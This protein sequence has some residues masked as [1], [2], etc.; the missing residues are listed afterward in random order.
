MYGKHFA[1]M[2]NG[3]M[4][5]KPALVFAVWG[6]CISLQRPATRGG[7][8][9]VE[10]NPLLLAAIFA[11]TPE[12][13]CEALTVLEAPDPAS[14]SKVEQGR[15]L[16]LESDRALGP[17][18]Y[19]VVNG[20]K[21]RK[22][23][24]EEERR[25]YLREAQQKHR[26]KKAG[27]KAVDRK[28]LST[29]VNPSQPP[30]TQ[31]EVEVKEEVEAKEGKSTPLP[32]SSAV[33]VREDV[34][35]VDPDSAFEEAWSLVPR[36]SGKGDARKWYLK[37]IRSTVARER[38]IAGI[39]GCIRQMTHERRAIEK[40]PYGSTL[41]TQHEDYID[42]QPGGGN[43]NGSAG[44]HGRRTAAEDAE[45]EASFYESEFHPES[46]T[47]EEYDARKRARREELSPR[48]RDGEPDAE[49]RDRQHAAEV[50]RGA[51]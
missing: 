29:T 47:L 20:Q 16:V 3:S 8:C 27:N 1:S 51:V 35:T 12:A 21:Y 41:F 33:R 6:Y 2:Y 19:R 50:L 5:G 38:L 23:R 17:M 40:I 13:V 34:L 24:D 39:Q 28:Q 26:Q 30:L 49:F 36:K 18:Q 31:G 45:R 9:Y 10:I 15:R 7:P 48:Q 32:I 42:W 46:E 25:V 14:R 11:T 22:I 4:F 43:G 44:T 37:H